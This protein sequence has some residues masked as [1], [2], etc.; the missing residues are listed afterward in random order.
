MFPVSTCT[1]LGEV[2]ENLEVTMK[3]DGMPVDVQSASPI[4]VDVQEERREFL[5]KCGRFS[6]YTTPS[7]LLL[8]SGKTQQ[9]GTIS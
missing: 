5:A 8:L 2:G 4:E 6:A 3:R 7:V 1:P 9:P